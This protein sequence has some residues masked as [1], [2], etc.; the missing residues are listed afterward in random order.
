MFCRQ[1]VLVFEINPYFE[2]GCIFAGHSE[3]CL[4][5]IHSIY[6]GKR[7]CAGKRYG[8]TARAGADI[9]HVQIA[10]AAVAIG[11]HVDESG[12]LGTRYQHGWSHRVA[13]AHEQ[14]TADGIL[15]RFAVFYFRG[16]GVELRLHEG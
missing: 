10:A 7:Q 2:I 8:Y 15:H 3:S 4:G 16:H 9:E 14:C 1:Y 5:N 6:S 13:V 11:Y 12:C